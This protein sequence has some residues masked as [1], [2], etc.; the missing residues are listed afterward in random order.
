[1]KK[2]NYTK[3]DAIN[4]VTRDIP[5]QHGKLHLEGM[6]VRALIHAL[7]KCDPDDL[8]V[9]MAEMTPET[10][11]V[12]MLIGATGGVLSEGNCGTSFIVGP[13][14]VRAMENAGMVK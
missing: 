1:M 6:T 4:Y 8:V 11:N 3:I 10:R 7:Q 12:D 5:N 9:Y 2:P 13:E 14:A